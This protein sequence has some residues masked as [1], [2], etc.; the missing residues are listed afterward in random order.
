MIRVTDAGGLRTLTLD[1]TDKANSLTRAMLL[2]IEAAVGSAAED[3][4]RAL[5]LTGAGK[6]FSAGADLD[7]ARAGLATDPV[8]ERL[9]A[10]VAA[11]PCLTIAALN[12]T[13]AGGAMGMALACDLRIAVPG[14][15]LFYPVMKLGFRPQPSDVRRLRTL[16]GPARTKMI[17]M[18]GVK[19]SAE[20]A[21]AWG[22][23]D[24]LV[25]SEDLLAEAEALAT[26]ALAARPGHVEAIKGMVDLP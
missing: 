11:L 19:A 4:V 9:S 3:G 18:A 22:L 10:A 2:E 23:I 16:V 15:K 17:L 25:P 21:L 24:R 7:E 14:A 5:V 1:R 13:L 26:D 8:W 20:E 6:V 12:G